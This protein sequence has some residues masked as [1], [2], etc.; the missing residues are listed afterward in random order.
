MARHTRRSQK[1]SGTESKKNENKTR[2]RK[3]DKGATIEIKP[4]SPGALIPNQGEND[5]LEEETFLESN[6]PIKFSKPSERMNVELSVSESGKRKLH[7]DTR[8]GELERTEPKMCKIKPKRFED[9]QNRNENINIQDIDTKFKR[10][11]GANTCMVLCCSSP[12]HPGIIYHGFP[13]PDY[14]NLQKQWLIACGRAL[15][16]SILRHMRVCR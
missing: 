11:S 8:C 5:H 14:P 15:N 3:Y 1:G 13:K 10:R 2:K 9:P 12:R 7:V 6:I 16:T 4:I